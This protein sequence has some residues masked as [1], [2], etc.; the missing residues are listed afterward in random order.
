LSG[1]ARFFNSGAHFFH[2][3]FILA[4]H[5]D[6]INILGVLSVGKR[7][8]ELLLPPQAVAILSF[9]Q[10]IL[11]TTKIRQIIL[12]LPGFFLSFLDEPVML[13]VTDQRRDTKKASGGW[14]GK[15]GPPSGGPFIP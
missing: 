15:K 13:C 2:L 11:T 3:D 4:Q 1:S 7:N 10:M 14:Q 8:S 12:N 6:R 9:I 5:G